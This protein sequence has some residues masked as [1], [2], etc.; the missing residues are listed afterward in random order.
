[1]RSPESWPRPQMPAL[2]LSLC[3][4]HQPASC[5]QPEPR[6]GLTATSSPIRRGCRSFACFCYRLKKAGAV[7]DPFLE[8]TG[9]Q[10]PPAKPQAP[11]KPSGEARA[12]PPAVAAQQPDPFSSTPLATRPVCT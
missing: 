5:A 4:R 7:D 6:A 10:A 2:M 1:M 3:S 9:L 11:L 8:L 12:N